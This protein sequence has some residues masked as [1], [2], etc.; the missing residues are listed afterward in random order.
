MSIEER[1][2]RFTPK[3]S[4]AFCMARVWSGGQGG[5]C[6][7][8]PEKRG[9]CLFHAEKD[10]ETGLSHGRVDGAIPEDKLLEF[11]AFTARSSIS[12]ATS[13]ERS[14]SDRRAKT[15]E[16][17]TE[18]KS[19]TKAKAAKA[20]KEA[21]EASAKAK[22]KDRARDD[23]SVRTDR[24]RCT[25]RVWAGGEGGQCKA[26]CE[27]EGGLCG[28]HQAEAD[29]LGYPKHGFIHGEIPEAKYKEFKKE[30]ATELT[31]LTGQEGM[32]NAQSASSTVWQH[33]RPASFVA[34]FQYL[35]PE[36]GKLR[37]AEAPEAWREWKEKVKHLVKQHQQAR[38]CDFDCMRYSAG[39][40]AAP[41]SEEERY[42]EASA[43]LEAS[44]QY[45]RHSGCRFRRASF[46]DLT[47]EGSD[48]ELQAAKAQAA[49][50]VKEFLAR[51]KDSPDQAL[52]KDFN[53][54]FDALWT[55][56]M[57]SS[58]VARCHQLDLWPPSPSPLGIAEDDVEYEADTTSLF[59]IAQR[60][61]NHDCR[62]NASTMRRLSTASFLADFAYEAGIPTPDFFRSR[63]PVLDKFEQMADEYEEQMQFPPTRRSHSWWLP[64]NLIWDAGSWLYGIFSRALRPIVDAA[65][66][67]RTKK[68]E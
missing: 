51:L 21:K 24:P 4:A 61:Y 67:S 31:S 59:A 39:S 26:T 32:V 40:G 65:C 20:A 1:S 42:L 13:R 19:K 57:R 18:S 56:S 25:A 12:P 46:E 62:R 15:Q 33:H 30:A 7:L 8:M 34:A 45:A 66:T 63:S 53:E 44:D 29:Q 36:K 14:R 38:F 27:I 50:V 60:L 43:L 52:L 16:T 17:K 64:W 55:E 48:P 28:R 47:E 58:M 11:E 49:P 54:A 35:S 37:K 41:D 5:Q 3:V 68:L 23:R 6:P 10:E 9:L 2:K 22:A